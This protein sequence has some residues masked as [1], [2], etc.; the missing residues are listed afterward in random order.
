MSDVSYWSSQVSRLQANPPK[1]SSSYYNQSFVDRLNEAQRNID[2]LVAEK[3][4]SWGATQQAQNDYDTFRGTMSS[5][6]DVYK[7]AESEFGVQN[8]MFDYEKN[9]KAL[10]LAET[11]LEALPSTINAGSNR[12]LT[13]TQRERAYN[14]LSNQFNKIQTNLQKQNKVFEDVWKNARESQMAYAQSVVSQQNT[15]M[16]DYNAAWMT[17]VNKYDNIVRQWQ[18]AR[19]EKEQIGEDY[20]QWQLMQ[21]NAAKAQYD[22]ELNNATKRYQAAMQTAMSQNQ[23]N[24][25]AATYVKPVN[26]WSFGGG[27]VIKKNSRGEAEYYKDNLRITAGEFLKNAK[28]DWNTWNA[29]WNAGVSTKGVGSDTIDAFSRNRGINKYDTRYGYLFNLAF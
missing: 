5:Y 28:T 12:V 29:I 26:T 1:S 8:A 14:V 11:T 15:Q 10:A 19:L 9:K 17:A 24:S 13:Q 27:Y 22:A 21:Y 4:K 23:Y 3:D 7:N 6:E 2:G 25:Q 18:N 20:R 16:N